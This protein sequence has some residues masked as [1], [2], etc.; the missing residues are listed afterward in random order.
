MAELAF[1]TLPIDSPLASFSGLRDAYS[2]S[3][4]IISRTTADTMARM[5]SAGCSIQMTA[6]KIGTQGELKMA[7]TPGPAMNV[8]I[9]PRSRSGC[10]EAGSP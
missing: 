6:M 1:W 7:L 8:R 9:A 4:A 10:A 3:T 2:L 5:P